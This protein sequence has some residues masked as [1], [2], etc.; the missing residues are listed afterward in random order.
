M[1]ETDKAKILYAFVYGAVYSLRFG[2]RT[3]QRVQLHIVLQ[4]LPLLD[5]LSIDQK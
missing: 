2:H 4:R 5:R 3:I 1:R